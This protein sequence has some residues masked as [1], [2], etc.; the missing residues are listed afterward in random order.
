M[1]RAKEDDW[2]SFG[3]DDL[4]EQTEERLR[5][6]VESALKD[7]P[8]VSA[9][10]TYH[11]AF[12]GEEDTNARRCD[13][14]GVWLTD[15]SCPDSINGLMPGYSVEGTFLCAQHYEMKV[16]SGEIPRPAEYWTSE[17][18]DG[19]PPKLPQSS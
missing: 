19:S 17:D 8:M 12:L 11:Y 5:H 1:S 2:L 7:V 3:Y 10:G 16:D 18:E 6:A 14:C 15:E 13:V 9:A 4:I